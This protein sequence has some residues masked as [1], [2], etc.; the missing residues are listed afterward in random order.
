[1]YKIPKIDFS[2]QTQINV[3]QYLVTKLPS[4]FATSHFVSTSPQQCAVRQCA[5]EM[6]NY[7]PSGSLMNNE[8][9]FSCY[10]LFL[11]PNIFEFSKFTEPLSINVI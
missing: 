3:P 2:Q 8:F 1:M 5:M 4:Q 6:E 11:V 9:C 10:M 7:T